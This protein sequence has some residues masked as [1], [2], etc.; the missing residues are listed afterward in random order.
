M[1]RDNI[2]NELAENIL[3]KQMD[4]EEKKKKADLFIENIGTYTDLN[5][6]FL[7]LLNQLTN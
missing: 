7:K 6:N 3:T 2:N 1:K 5:H 4:I